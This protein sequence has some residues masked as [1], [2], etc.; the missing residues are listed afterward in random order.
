MSYLVEYGQLACSDSHMPVPNLKPSL[1]LVE[2]IKLPLI[3]DTFRCGL[4]GQNVNSL[5][6]GIYCTSYVTLDRQPVKVKKL[7]K[8]WDGKLECYLR[9]VKNNPDYLPS[10]PY[11]FQFQ[12]AVVDAAV[13]KDGLALRHAKDYLEMNPTGKLHNAQLQ[14][15][16]DTCQKAIKNN[17][18]AI[19]YVPL[20][21]IH[22]SPKLLIEVLQKDGLMI[23]C[24]KELLDSKPFDNPY[25]LIP[26]KIKE[27]VRVAIQQNPA[28]YEHLPKSLRNDKKVVLQVVRR[29]GLY[30]KNLP[31]KFRDSIKIVR[32]AT[33]QNPE[34]INYATPSV[35]HFLLFER[36]EKIFGKTLVNI[37]KNI[38][39]TGTRL[40]GSNCSEAL[41]P[42]D[43]TKF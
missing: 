25:R 30:L 11:K 1:E 24:V 23:R 19:Q 21:I 29:D 38:V 4:R 14:G 13:E 22:K 43:Y 39:K 35:K 40:S 8:C 42:E 41:C 6:S 31:E 10:I 32:E 18:Y 20:N 27:V 2:M 33:K 7:S 36:W 28:S 37:F 9:A 5:R 34:A 16:V 3:K 17:I 12:K 15:A 26:S